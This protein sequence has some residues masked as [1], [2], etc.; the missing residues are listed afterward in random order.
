M[1]TQLH[2]KHATSVAIATN[3]TTPPHGTH[4]APV[5]VCPTL[6]NLVVA[7][8]ATVANL[9]RLY[10]EYPLSTQMLNPRPPPLATGA[11]LGDILHR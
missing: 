11:R 8:I 6:L 2:N 5:A 3:I 4:S 9:F 7:N 10:V 1:T